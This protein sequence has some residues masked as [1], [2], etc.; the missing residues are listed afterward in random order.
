MIDL[1][2]WGVYLVMPLFL[3]AISALFI[4]SWLYELLLL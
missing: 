3:A 1:L 2:E 4:F